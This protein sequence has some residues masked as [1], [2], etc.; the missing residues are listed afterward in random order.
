MRFKKSFLAIS[1]IGL[2]GLSSAASSQ[3]PNFNF[4]PKV[5][6]QVQSTGQQ[7]SQRSAQ[8]NSVNNQQPGVVIEEVIEYEYPDIP[9]QIDAI[10]KELKLY[11]DEQRS[12][13]SK[14]RLMLL[15]IY[16]REQLKEIREALERLERQ[17]ATKDAF[18]SISELPP[19]TIE[20]LRYY[21]RDITKAKNKPLENVDQLIES[22]EVNLSSNKPIDVYLTS[23]NQASI[24]FYD[25]GGNPW[26]IEGQPHYDQSAF[27]ISTTHPK[28]HI[29]L[30]TLKRPFT[31]SNAIINLQGLDVPLIIRLIGSE[32]KVHS[33]L[34]LRLPSFGPGMRQKPSVYNMVD[35]ASPDMMTVLN[36][37]PL[38]GALEYDIKGVDDADAY[39][40][41]GNLYIRTK[42]LLLVPPPKEASN[43]PSG[44]KSFV[45]PAKRDLL[46]S[47]DGRYVEAYVEPKKKIQIENKD[48]FFEE[49]QN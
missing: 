13:Q 40:K 25:R 24:V 20:Q 10:D 3:E 31:E 26:P 16:E 45:I 35:N 21:E 8:S 43:L 32:S 23:G 12:L 33:R 1:I 19:Q 5:P 44:F 4:S 27:N 22:K 9:V 39:Y 30:F 29:A 49:T 7:P 11:E 17:R 42:H 2:T 15:D 34:S 6:P 28:N 14:E 38:E 41:N 36:G 48:N 18:G 37:D 47:V 46:F